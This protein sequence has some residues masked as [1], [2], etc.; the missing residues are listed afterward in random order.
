MRHVRKDR[1]HM[2]DAVWSI[3]T[4]HAQNEVTRAVLLG[5]APQSAYVERLLYLIGGAD[6]LPPE[7]CRR[8]ACLLVC[9]FFS[10][11]FSFP[12]G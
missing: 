6:D 1:Q 2:L 12:R 10:L 4:E 7:V 9:L 3:N 8:F 5:D 11:F